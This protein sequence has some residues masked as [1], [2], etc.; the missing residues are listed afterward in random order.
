MTE[1]ALTRKQVLLLADLATKFPKAAW[2]S[3][4]T[5]SKNGIGESVTVKFTMFDTAKDFDTTV[6]ITD[7]NVW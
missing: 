1:F 2:F 3:L 7:F 5:E 4:K 6:D